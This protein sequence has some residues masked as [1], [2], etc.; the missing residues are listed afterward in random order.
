MPDRT[1]SGQRAGRPPVAELLLICCAVV[2]GQLAVL[3]RPGGSVARAA[4]PAV[5]LPA[6][7]D[8]DVVAA[9]AART[10]LGRAPT[11]IAQGAATGRDADQGLVIQY[12][13]IVAA[14]TAA[15]ADCVWQGIGRRTTL[16]GGAAKAVAEVVALL[17]RCR[18]TARG[19]DQVR[20][21]GRARCAAHGSAPRG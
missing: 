11:W 1:A 4:L 9:R 13:M 21:V 14:G 16:A 17:R 7:G 15:P 20:R 3:T 10:L 12:G 8:P 19:V 6:G 2:D 18:R 5:P